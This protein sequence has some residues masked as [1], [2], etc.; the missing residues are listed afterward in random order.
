[1]PRSTPWESSEGALGGA[2]EGAEEHPDLLPPTVREEE[3]ECAS[4]PSA[5]APVAAHS[6]TGP[7]DLFNDDAFEARGSEAGIVEAIDDD[8]LAIVQTIA[9]QVGTSLDAK[10]LG[11]PLVTAKARTGWGDDALAVSCVEKLRHLGRK[12]RDRSAFLATDLARLDGDTVP[13]PRMRLAELMHDLGVLVADADD[14][15]R[16]TDGINLGHEAPLTLVQS[17]LERRN[18]PDDVLDA[19]TFEVPSVWDVAPGYVELIITIVSDV[20]EH[21]G[22]RVEAAREESRRLTE[23][24]E[25][26]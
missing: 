6:P 25:G 26:R 17:G 3:E 21:A 13:S 23:Y 9:K 19:W 7:L 12:V 5:C 11:P 4:A 20:L 18:F 1:M 10:R 14:I 2:A 24:R 8:V 22:P 16:Q 15:Q